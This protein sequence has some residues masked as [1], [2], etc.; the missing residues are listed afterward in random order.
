MRLWVA[1]LL[2]VAGIAIMPPGVRRMVRN[3]LFFNVPGALTD[4]EK[5]E[6]IA[7][8]AAWLATSPSP[9]GEG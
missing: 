6:V 8:K 7:A 2:I 5:A 3:I 1:K 4:K 9:T